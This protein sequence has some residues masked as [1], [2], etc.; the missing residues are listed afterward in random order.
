[1]CL[2]ALAQTCQTLNSGNLCISAA[3]RGDT[4]RVQLKAPNT[5]GWVGFGIGTGMASADIVVCL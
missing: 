5:V 4:V 2:L 1:M 3:D